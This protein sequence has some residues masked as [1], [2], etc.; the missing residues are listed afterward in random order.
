M[1]FGLVIVSRL[2]SVVMPG[3][4]RFPAKNAATAN[5]ANGVSADAPPSWKMNCGGSGL[6][7]LMAL[8][9]LFGSLT[10]VFAGTYYVAT[11][12]VSG[13]SGLSTNSPWDM[14][15]AL[16]KVPA[17]STIIVMP[18]TWS[19]REIDVTKTQ[20]TLKSQVK[21][22]ARFL[23]S[24]GNGIAV[25]TSGTFVEGV[26][27]DGFEVAYAHNHGISLYATNCTV[28]NCWI[29]HCAT[30]SGVVASGIMATEDSGGHY[31]M[32]TLLVECNLVE[33]IGNATEHQFDHGLYV[34]GTNITIR[35]NVCRY[36][37][38]YG[39]QIF[40]S[41]GSGTKKAQVYDNLSYGNGIGA[42]VCGSG[43]GNCTLNAYGNTFVGAHA[44]DACMSSGLNAS[45]T[46][47]NNILIGG[48]YV[49]NLCCA[50]A[51][52]NIAGDYN[53][54]NK[55]DNL[56]LGAHGILTNYAGFVNTNSGL[57][58][59]T[60][61]SAARGKALSTACGP[62]DFFGN[63]QSSV[64]DIGA[65]QYSAL[66]SSDNRVLDP[67]PVSPNYWFVLTPQ[68]VPQGLHVV[69]LTNQ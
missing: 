28:R 1:N 24:P 59:L 38:G 21:W 12:G 20:L 22:G 40:D 66:Y 69:P 5:Y 39:I 61:A 7:R 47:T 18:G 16:A 65:F 4:N 6:G 42:F 52:F 30:N 3:V 67:S 63:A 60:A 25:Y 48:V 27:I 31:N 62:M 54:I 41:G 10:T 29:H 26:T 33:Y 46:C 58:W 19:G 45:F 68:S 13:N 35:A 15:T 11:N 36:N 64:S 49:M 2:I 55:V 23:N 57:Y 53:L 50:G 14:T 56:P 44:L 32:S 8:S 51:T 34:F 37:T 9:V 43:G 17:G